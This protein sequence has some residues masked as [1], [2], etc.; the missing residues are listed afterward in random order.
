MKKINIRKLRKPIHI[1][2]GERSCGKTYFEKKYGEKYG[3]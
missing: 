1:C 2:Y 3:K